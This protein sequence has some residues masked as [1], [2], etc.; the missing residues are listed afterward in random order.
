MALRVR[1]PP[2]LPASEGG[3]QPPCRLR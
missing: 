1:P 3:A 2:G